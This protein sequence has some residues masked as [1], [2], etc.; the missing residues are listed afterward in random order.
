MTAKVIPA[1]K[2]FAAALRQFWKHKKTLLGTLATVSIP[3]A[4]LAALGLSSDAT[5]SAYS[6]FLTLIMNLAVIWLITEFNAGRRPTF[7]QA[8]YRGTGALVRMM[9]LAV[10]FFFIAVP[11]LIGALFY[12]QGVTGSIVAAS[13]PEKLLLGMVWLVLSLPSAWLAARFFLS[14]FA[15]VEQD[16]APL[17]A[18]AY[19]NSIT[20]GHT[21]KI[22]ARLL[23][24]AIVVLVTIAAP[25]V[26]L[27]LAKLNAKVLTF[28][29]AMLQL[30]SVLILLPL[31]NLYL[32]NLYK[33]LERD[34]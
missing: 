7:S 30:L 17:A 4:A 26:V 3:L 20:K 14:M 19:T 15:L 23:V 13:G 1:R 16:T 5:F 25:A 21:L 34:Q 28:F 33:A 27:S 24:L 32:F 8:Y 22:L 6:S 18:L 29:M 11:F 2:L 10:A 31:I 9:L 12:L